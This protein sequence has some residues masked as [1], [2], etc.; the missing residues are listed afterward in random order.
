MKPVESSSISTVGHDP[1][2][3]RLTVQF[4][5]GETYHYDGVTA[6]HHAALIGAKS[7]GAHFQKH[8]RN[9]FK[10]TKA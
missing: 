3:K 9:R 8:I 2:R 4:K 7:V 6:D 5:S 1:G 10:A